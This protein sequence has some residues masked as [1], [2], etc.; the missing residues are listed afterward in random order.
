MEEA[1]VQNL[2]MRSH[3]HFRELYLL[4]FYLN[5]QPRESADYGCQMPHS[6]KLNRLV[7]KDISPGLAN[8]S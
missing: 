5:R 2:Q 3:G 8:Y 7:R 4:H 1:V 6:I